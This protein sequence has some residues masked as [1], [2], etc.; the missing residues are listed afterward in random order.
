MIS[1]PLSLMYGIDLQTRCLVA[2]PAEPERTYFL[3]G[4]L[5]LKQENQ[6]FTV[7]SFVVCKWSSFSN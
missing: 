5:S 1:E 7:K 3:V 4:T 6:V 2:V